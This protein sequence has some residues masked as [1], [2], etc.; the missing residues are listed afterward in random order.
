MENQS[1][2]LYKVMLE[3][4]G[5][6]PKHCKSGCHMR[7]VS[8]HERAPPRIFRAGRTSK[9]IGTGVFNVRSARK[10]A[11]TRARPERQHM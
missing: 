7:V 1:A 2:A 4:L 10:T 6:R 5:G 8:L 11:K 3:E 9:N